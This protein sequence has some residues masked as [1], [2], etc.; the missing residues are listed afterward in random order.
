[1]STP[2]DVYQKIGALLSEAAR[3]GWAKIFFSTFILNRECSRMVTEQI[4]AESNRSDIDIEFSRVFEIN[5]A[6]REYQDF[7]V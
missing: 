3:S 6:C 5:D 7:C 4:H 1:M 2:D